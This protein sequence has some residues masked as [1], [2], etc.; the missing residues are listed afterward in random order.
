MKIS[1]PGSIIDLPILTEE[2]EQIIT[3]FGL[4]HNIDFVAASFVRKASDVEF[5]KNLLN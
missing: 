5:I 3:E 4:R 2:D 1:L